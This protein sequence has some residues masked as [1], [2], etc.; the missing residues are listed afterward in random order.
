VAAKWPQHGRNSAIDACL[1][2]ESTGNRQTC[3]KKATAT[4]PQCGTGI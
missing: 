4:V 3:G 1:H 2:N